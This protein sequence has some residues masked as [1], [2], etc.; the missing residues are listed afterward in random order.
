MTRAVFLDRDGTLNER[1]GDHD[2]VRSPTEFV[3]LPGSRE[4]IGK[5][6][7]AGYVPLVVSNQRGVARGLVDPSSLRAIDVRIQM[8]LEPYGVAI[9]AFSY[10]THDDTDDCDC[11]KPKPGMLV[12]LGQ[13]LG[14]DLSESWMIGDSES[15]VL[16]GDAAGCQT[17]LI[18]RRCTLTSATYVAPTLAAAAELVVGATLHETRVG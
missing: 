1:P 17:V 18:A 12:A 7:S 8:D 2:Y 4:A 9:R 6:W 11:R 5:L 13:E 15:D 14:L 16:A 10:C 3:W